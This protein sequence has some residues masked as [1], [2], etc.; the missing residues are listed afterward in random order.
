[1]VLRTRDTKIYRIMIMTIFKKRSKLTRQEVKEL[2]AEIYPIRHE[3][4]EN[5][6]KYRSY[7]N[8]LNRRGNG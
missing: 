5:M 7:I 1:M 3:S 8:F 2:L 6:T 4:E